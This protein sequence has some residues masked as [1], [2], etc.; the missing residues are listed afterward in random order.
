MGFAEY[1][2]YLLHRIFKRGVLQQDND[3]DKLT[4]ALGP[5][6]DA[7]QEAIFLVREQALVATATGAALDALGKE[8]GL[9]RHR[10]EP[11]EYYRRRLLSAY[12][13]YQ[14]AGTIP[15]IKNVLRILGYPNAEIYELYK[16]GVTQPFHNGQ[17]RYDGT[18]QHQGGRRWAEFKIITDIEEGRT[19]TAADVRVLVDAINKVKPAH[20]KLAAFTLGMI[21]PAE[22]LPLD[23]ELRLATGVQCRDA[24]GSQVTHA[25]QAWVTRDGSRLY[26]GEIWAEKMQLAM[27]QSLGDTFPGARTYAPA[28]RHDGG[29]A[30][31]KHAGSRI[32][33]G[34][35]VYDGQKQHDG[36]VSRW[37]CW[38][39]YGDC[40]VTHNGLRRYNYGP[41]HDGKIA[42]TM[43]ANESFG[44]RLKRQGQVIEEIAS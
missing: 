15:G 34:F 9:P 11:D 1:F 16:D 3:A 30:R 26:N 40:I 19:Y 20:T 41:V 42:R 17:Y 32:R 6:Y 38:A 2:Y 14:A 28:F 29:G 5:N 39:R 36:S 31:W 10:D 43:G 18:I 35:V 22:A 24:F 8:R 13:L 44:L 21:I 4:R 25:A 12:S 23:H 27:R 33:R 7:A 37:T